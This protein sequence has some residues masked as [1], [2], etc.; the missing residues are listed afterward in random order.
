MDPRA[1][2]RF[3]A[4]RTSGDRAR[5]APAIAMDTGQILLMRHAEKRD[6]PLDPDLSAAGQARARQLVRYIPESF[7]TPD[8][9]FATALSNHSRRPVETLEPLSQAIGITIDAGFADQDYGALAH[10]ILHTPHYDGKLIVIC[11]H[12]GNIP[13][14]A[15]ALKAKS[16]EY[17]DPW[18]PAVFDLILRFDFVEGVP[19]VSRVVE[20]F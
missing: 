2:E 5:G 17:P 4:P 14:L 12:H 19:T 16:G 1:Q 15:R 3:H 8:F 18:D 20:P 9:L 7:G 6:D 10:E 11:W 13:S